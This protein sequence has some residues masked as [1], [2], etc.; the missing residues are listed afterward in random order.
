MS[1][2]DLCPSCDLPL[3]TD[4]DFQTIPAGEGEWLCWSAYGTKCEPID[5][6]ERALKVQAE[7]DEWMKVAEYFLGDFVDQHTPQECRAEGMRRAL[8]AGAKDIEQWKE[9][10][11]GMV[12]AVAQQ[13]REACA[14]W[15]ADYC[16]DAKAAG[17]RALPLVTEEPAMSKS[18]QRRLAV[19]TKKD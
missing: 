9:I 17:V 7:R 1:V 6:R 19:Q 3:A 10:L 5:W 11:E 12:R 4:E 2:S 13:Q 15:V 16:S 8:E 14:Q 18:E